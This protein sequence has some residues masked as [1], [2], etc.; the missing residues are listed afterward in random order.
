MAILLSINSNK[1]TM[2]TIAVRSYDMVFLALISKFSDDYKTINDSQ[3]DQK[4]VTF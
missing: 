3:H 4:H 2:V 1:T